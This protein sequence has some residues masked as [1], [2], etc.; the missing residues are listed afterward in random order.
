MFWRTT[1]ELR[2]RTVSI[3]DNESRHTRAGLDVNQKLTRSIRSAAHLA[4]KDTP[5]ASKGI[6]KHTKSIYN[7]LGSWASGWCMSH[8]NY[9][10]S[11]TLGVELWFGTGWQSPSFDQGL[12]FFKPSCVCIQELEKSVTGVCMRVLI[13]L[14]WPLRC[15]YTQHCQCW[16]HVWV[17]QSP[18]CIKPSLES[19]HRGKN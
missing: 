7:T 18:T 3:G 12:K 14:G 11:G 2:L 4:L 15:W 1:S 16:G 17:S 5:S 6:P 10:V 9:T 8:L 19:S 13:T